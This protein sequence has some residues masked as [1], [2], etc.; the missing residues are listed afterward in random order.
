MFI[1][2]RCLNG[3]RDTM[4]N[5]TSICICEYWNWFVNVR[6]LNTKTWMVNGLLIHINSVVE[7]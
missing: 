6:G 1:I 7:W 4:F 3:Y 5:F 2:S